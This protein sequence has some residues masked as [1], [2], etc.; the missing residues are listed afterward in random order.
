LPEVTEAPPDGYDPTTAL[1][2][3][4]TAWETKTKPKAKP[5]KAVAKPAAVKRKPAKSK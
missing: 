1:A 5:A 3:L 4:Q 2:R